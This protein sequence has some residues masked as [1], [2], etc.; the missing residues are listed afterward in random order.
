MATKEYTDEEKQAIFDWKSSFNDIQIE[1]TAEIRAEEAA[2]D[3]A[4]EEA[5]I[6]YMEAWQLKREQE[7]PSEQQVEYEDGKWDRL[8]EEIW[9]GDDWYNRYYTPVDRVLLNDTD[10]KGVLETERFM[11]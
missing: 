4:E 9:P 2:R 1:K 7:R 10:F 3:A 11:L 5:A 8:L 6:A